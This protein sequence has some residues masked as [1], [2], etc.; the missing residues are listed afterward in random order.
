[1]GWICLFESCPKCKK[2]HMFKPDVCSCG[3]DFKAEK[4]AEVQAPCPKCKAIVKYEWLECPKC[5]TEVNRLF[6]YPCPKCKK[7]VGI[8]DKYCECGE[9]LIW[10]VIAC[11]FC[12][13]EIPAEALACPKCG[14][15][16]YTDESAYVPDEYHCP[17]CG[18]RLATASSGC[19]ICDQPH[20]H[21]EYR[22]EE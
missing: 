6:R 10:E 12:R 17:R 9:R 22:Y 16:L 5:H 15:N 3:H 4:E 13:K 21:H 19:P 11:P 7:F 18:F 2:R 8:K 1:M 14:K 20:Y